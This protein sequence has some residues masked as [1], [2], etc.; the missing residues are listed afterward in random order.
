VIEDFVRISF[1]DL[2]LGNY[3]CGAESDDV[4][5]RLDADGLHF[6]FVA[7]HGGGP[8]V[9]LTAMYEAKPWQKVEEW[10]QGLPPNGV[11]QVELT[12]ENFIQMGVLQSKANQMAGTYTWTLQN[13]NY[14]LLWEG[15][16]GQ[17]GNCIGTYA[18]V[19]DFVRLTSTTDD[20][21]GEVE[22]LQW[23]LDDDGLHVHL[24]ATKN[25]PFVEMKANF[26][27]KPWQKVEEWST[28]LLPNGVWQVELTADDFV[29]RGVL[30]SVA[31]AE[32]AGTYTLTL[33]DGKSI[34][35]WQGLQGQTGKCQANYDVIKD[36]VRFTYYTETNE[37]LGEVDDLQWRL[38]E[39][40]LH[41]HVLDVKNAPFTEIKAYLEAKP[42]QKVADS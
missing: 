27:A 10:S 23:R 15:S 38:D 19:D 16:A 25:I 35:V 4:Q 26:E 17:S 37:C 33:K 22:D 30:R 29:Q 32:W 31:E 12:A 20:C 5:W 28:G 14:I 7:N 13:G 42:W 1:V 18:V 3:D 8:K 6:H 24:L 40:G 41:F 11:W 2:G 36:F 21:P 34:G 39:E 9:E